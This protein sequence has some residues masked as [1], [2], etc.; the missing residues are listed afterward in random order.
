MENWILALFSFGFVSF[1]I[2]KTSSH[3][4][5][6]FVDLLTESKY[7][8]A[9]AVIFFIGFLSRLLFIRT[10]PVGLNQD[11]SSIGYEAYLLFVIVNTFDLEQIKIG[12]IIF[13]LSVINLTL[14]TFYNI[15]LR[16]NLLYKSGYV[17]KLGNM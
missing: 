11:E 14:H 15:L 16:S 5:K 6:S 9:I 12:C 13:I 2:Y 10:M 17:Y 8:I 7:E 4:K 1:Y 3:H